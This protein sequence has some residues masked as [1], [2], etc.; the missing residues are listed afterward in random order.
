MDEINVTEI[1]TELCCCPAF[2]CVWFT[3]DLFTE[4]LVGFEQPDV[5]HRAPEAAPASPGNEAKG[6]ESSGHLWP[7]I[8]KPHNVLSHNLCNN[9]LIHRVVIMSTPQ[10]RKVGSDHNYQVTK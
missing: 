8:L 2:G 10:L 5:L 7:F 9:F 3:C 1:R 6:T 4:A